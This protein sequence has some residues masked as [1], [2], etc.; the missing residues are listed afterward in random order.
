MAVLEAVV[1]LPDHAVEE[2]ALEDARR[3]AIYPKALAPGSSK[4]PSGAHEVATIR[5]VATGE[6]PSVRFGEEATEMFGFPHH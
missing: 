1:E 5:A 2:V 3:R 6:A 4:H